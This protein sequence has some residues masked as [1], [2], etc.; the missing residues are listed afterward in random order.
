MQK[1]HFYYLKIIIIIII[2][3]LKIPKCPALRNCDAPCDAGVVDYQKR[4]PAVSYNVNSGLGRQNTRT[5][6]KINQH[7]KTCAEISS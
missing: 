1:Y 4:T 3:H 7:S 5:C 2:L 6:T